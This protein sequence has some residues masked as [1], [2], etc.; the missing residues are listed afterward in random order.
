MKYLG[1][2]LAK[3]TEDLWGR[4]QNLFMKEVKEDLK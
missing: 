3:C 2:I 4:L 1:I